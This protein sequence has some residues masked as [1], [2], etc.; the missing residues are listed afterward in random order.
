MKYKWWFSDKKRLHM[1]AFYITLCNSMH[2]YLQSRLYFSI[3]QPAIYTDV[4]MIMI[5]PKSQSVN[6]QVYPIEGAKIVNNTMTH[7]L[8]KVLFKSH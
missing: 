5:D 2:R 1:Y 3:N 4:F 8:E 7:T 6:F